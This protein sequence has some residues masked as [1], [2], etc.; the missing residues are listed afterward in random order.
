MSYVV[1][2][3]VFVLPRGYRCNVIRLPSGSV[4]QASVL[5]CVCIAK[6]STRPVMYQNKTNT[7]TLNLKPALTEYRVT[8]CL[9]N[10]QMSGNMTAV[11]DFTKNQGNVREIIFSGKSGLKLF[12][13]NCIFASVQVLSS[14][15][16]MI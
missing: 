10:L 6:T 9:E 8:T 2:E 15:T 11:R 12:I 3:N 13:V 5:P 1:K 14:S 7:I 16:R 4:Y